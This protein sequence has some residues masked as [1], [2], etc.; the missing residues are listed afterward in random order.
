MFVTG[1]IVTPLMLHLKQTK[2]YLPNTYCYTFRVTPTYLPVGAALHLRIP[3]A[4]KTGPRLTALLPAYH[5]Y[6]LGQRTPRLSTGPKEAERQHQLV[7]NRASIAVNS[8]AQKYTLEQATNINQNDSEG[9]RSRGI[10]KGR[11]DSNKSE[12]SS[13]KMMGR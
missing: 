5:I 3:P 2:K 7:A 13:N 12:K 1:D 6:L 4:L 9:R 8:Q 11:M 10:R